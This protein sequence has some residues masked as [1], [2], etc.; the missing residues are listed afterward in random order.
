MKPLSILIF[1]GYYLPYRGGYVESLHGLSKSLVKEGHTVRIV[2]NNVSKAP[3]DEIID[4]VHVT[5]LP[6]W[7]LLGGTYPVVAPTPKALWMLFKLMRLKVDVV[8]TQTRFFVTSLLG[9]LY[10]TVRFKPLVHTERGAYHSVVQSRFVDL[11]SRF[12]DHTMGWFVV[13]R[14]KRNVGV[15][16]AACEFIKHLH[17]RNV[18]FIPNGVALPPTLSASGRISRRKKWG[19]SSSD[20]ILLF[21][22]RLVF[23]KGV[24]DV[25]PYLP[26]LIKKEPNLVLGIVGEGVYRET[27]ESEIKQAGL[28]KH[29]RFL[30]LLSGPEVIECMQ[31]SDFFINPS[32]SEGLPRSI[33][34]AAAAG[35]P[36]VASDVG[37]TIEI[38][39]HEK[40]GLIFQ[41]DQKQDMEGYLH[42]LL[43]NGDLC[44]QLGNAARKRVDT[45]FSWHTIL[46]SYVDLFHEVVQ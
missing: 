10:A 3:S 9:A 1:A 12:I 42:R 2:T 44:D 29:V 4:G 15:S 25:L 46:R 19:F 33:L 17:G 20:K 43:E 34:E 7:H 18:R 26:G 13:R 21:V 32:H 30:G 8:S 36:I 39:S 31:L 27:L 5:R 6:G 22:G 35:L 38:I 41:P 16:Q 23:A 40:S 28:S 14:A 11:A 45:D 24:Q 37:G